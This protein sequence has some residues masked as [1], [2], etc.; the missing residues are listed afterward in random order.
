MVSEL[1]PQDIK[2]LIDTSNVFV[3]KCLKTLYKNQTSEEKAILDTREENGVGFNSADA[4]IL[5]QFTEQILRWEA[6][7]E[8][9]RQY[10]FPLSPKQLGIAQKKLKKYARQLSINLQPEKKHQKGDGWFCWHCNY[11]LG[12]V[13]P[14][15][16]MIEC[17][18]CGTELEWGT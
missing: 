10:K 4:Y 15:E 1:E 13:V 3:L 12:D 9:L 14:E 8:S 11:K 16:Y 2:L 5:S 17:P 18:N 6:T 7:P